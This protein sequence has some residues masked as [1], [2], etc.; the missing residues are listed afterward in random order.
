MVFGSILSAAALMS[1]EMSFFWAR[2]Q[3]PGSSMLTKESKNFLMLK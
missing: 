1:T 3:M 2:M